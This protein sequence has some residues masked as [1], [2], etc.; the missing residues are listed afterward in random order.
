MTPGERAERLVAEFSISS[1][2][3]LDI[4]A[5][6]CDANMEVRY[7]PL[8]GCEATLVGYK[9]RAI[10]TVR[11]ASNRGRERFSIAHELGHW[12]LHRGKAFRCR[13]DDPSDNLASDTQLEK[14]ADSYASHLLMP[15][16]LFDPAVRSGARTPGFK[17]I[18]EVA[19]AFDVSLTAAC[20]RM[21]QVDS[22]PVIVACYNSE[23]I[24]WRSAAPHVPRRWR[25]RE[26]LDD[27]SLAYE[28]AVGA[29]HQQCVGKQPAEVWFSNDDADR[30][31]V[32]EHASPGRPGE[33]LVLIYLVDVKMFDVG[34]D[35]D[36]FERRYNEHGSYIHRN[37]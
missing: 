28:L 12:T 10:A 21:A 9:N 13:V 36:A 15:R 27:D 2:E 16:P 24:R 14:E 29:K 17:H 34:F 37:R 8:V 25:L 31:E 20:I 33:I 4:E 6:A 35:P 32:Q 5:I 18:D 11:P 22:L 19:Q 7:E 3:D 23:G 26:K 30:Y 1:P